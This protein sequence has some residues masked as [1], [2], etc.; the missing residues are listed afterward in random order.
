MKFNIRKA[1]MFLSLILFPITMN[2]LSPYVIYMAAAEG[3]INASLIVFL[4]LFVSSLFLGRAFCAYIC[5][6]GAAQDCMAQVNGKP[7]KGG[8]RNKI[9]YFIWAPWLLGIAALAIAAGGYARADLLFMTENGISVD[10]PGKYIIFYGIY[11]IFIAFSFISGKRAAC[12]TI[13][14]MAPFMVLGRRLGRF[15]KIPCLRL[16]VQ[17]DKCMDCKKCGQNCPMSID[18]NSLVQKGDM[19]DD[20]CILCGECAKACPGKAITRSFGRYQHTKKSSA[21]LD[22]AQRQRTAAPKEAAALQDGGSTRTGKI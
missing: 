4:L 2:Y 5:P 9:K 10:A 22:I 21:S 8:W 15:I 14:W 13:C 17:S 19:W 11:I 12:H 16:E 20:E 3:I 18:V 1:I 7:F 6:G